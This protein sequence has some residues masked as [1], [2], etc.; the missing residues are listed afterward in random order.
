MSA[1]L[2]GHS[3]PKILAVCTKVLAE[4]GLCLG[5]TTAQEHTYASALCAR[6]GLDRV[7]FTN[8]GTE[9]NLHAL[10]AARAFTGRQR[11]VVFGGGYHGGV[12]AFTG[13][14]P[15]PNNVDK[16]DW[17]VAKYNDLQS[18]QEAISA[19][20][21]AAVLV[22]GMQGGPGHVPGTSEFLLAVQEAAREASDPEAL[23]PGPNSASEPTRLTVPRPVHSSSSTRCKPRD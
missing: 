19:G 1:G 5:A 23:S 12:L 18:A 21:V 2:L 9:A 14:L 22:E 11:V 10:A 6:F 15:A 4:H 13:G 17:I 20:N 3:H 16:A 7:R 8:S